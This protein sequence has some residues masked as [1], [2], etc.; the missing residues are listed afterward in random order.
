MYSPW[1]CLNTSKNVFC[2]TTVSV[3]RLREQASAYF[4]TSS[5]RC[6][7]G[8]TLLT[9]LQSYI[10]C[11]VNGRPVKTISW[12]LRR[13]IISAHCHMRAAQPTYRKAEC[14]NSASSARP[15]ERSVGKEC[16]S[17]CR[18]RWA[19]YY[20]KKKLQYNECK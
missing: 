16:V 5:S 10:S 14:P 4:P 15:A 11:A 18:S 7:R 6:S 8:T 3:G 9:K 13:P 19:R 17:K 2:I 20:Y 12:N 1:F